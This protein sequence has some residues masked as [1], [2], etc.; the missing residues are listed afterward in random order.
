M[1]PLLDAEYI[2]SGKVFY[3][4]KDMPVLGSESILAAQAAECAGEQG[5]YW[6]MHDRIF[7]DRAAWVGRG[8]TT[9]TSAF[10][11]SAEDIGL[12]QVA[13]D[14]CMDSGRFQ[15]E[16]RADFEEG[17]RVGVR[18]TP[19]I[20]INGQVI[21]GFAPWDVFQPFLDGV[22]AEAGQ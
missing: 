9:A 15:D 18:G 8:Q 19:T 22:L 2:Q 6:E 16:V 1:L 14:G 11:T 13:F 21:P 4:Y 17:R 20:V 7:Q 3:V 5:L 12:D 10:K